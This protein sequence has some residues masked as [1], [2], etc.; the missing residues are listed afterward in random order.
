LVVWSFNSVESPW[1]RDEAARARKAKRLVPVLLDRAQIP[2]GFGSIN[3]EDFT[4]WN[5]AASAPQ[6]DV[7]YD[8]L[9]A[10]L[11]GR[12]PDGGVLA[13]WRRAKHSVKLVAVLGV[14]ALALLS[15]A[16][17]LVVWINGQAPAQTTLAAPRSD[18]AHLSGLVSQG[19]I[20]GEQAVELSQLLQ[21][22][23]LADVPAPRPAT[24]PA[25]TGA[26]SAAE[27]DESARETFADAASQLLQDPN[28]AVR[29]ATLEAARPRTRQA[30]IDKL[31]DIAKKDSPSSGAIYR[32]CAA[33]GALAQ[34]SRTQTALERAR[35]SNPQDRR[36]WRLLSVQYARNNDAKAAKG[37]ALV[38]EGLSAAAQGQPDRA[39]EALEEALPL[40]AAP[41]SKAFVLGQLGDAAAKR[42]DWSAA[43]RRYRAAIDLHTQEKNIA[44]V[45][46]DAPKLARAQF[47]QGEQAKACATLNAARRL[48]VETVARQLSQMCGND[49]APSTSP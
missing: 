37:A 32:Y 30:G 41:G 5:G 40:L 9:K 26:V 4:A 27:L 29:E 49:A 13:R 7:L 45:A 15:V 38:G 23:A 47:Q 1:V 21:Q 6:V 18:F 17:G 20:S 42:D 28:P 33:I 44:G 31:W 10:R 35:D 36:L 39:G 24:A 43:E 34:D 12:V 14:G 16:G 48:G 3:A 19:K 11:E 8:M 25:A 22:E 46:I 2:T